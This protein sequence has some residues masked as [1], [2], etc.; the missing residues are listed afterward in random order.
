MSETITVADVP[1]T[2][3]GQSRRG[4]HPVLPGTYELLED[5]ADFV[6]IRYFGEPCAINNLTNVTR[7]GAL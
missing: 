7:G 5:W 4:S 2:T 3:H 1:A 6:V